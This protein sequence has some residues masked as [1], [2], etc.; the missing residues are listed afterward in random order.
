MDQIRKSVG[1]GGL[2]RQD[3]VVAVQ[4]L[5]NRAI[6][7]IAL[8][9]D[10]RIGPATVA[11]IDYF[12]GHFLGLRPDGRVDPNGPT[13]IKLSTCAA[14]PRRGS[15]RIDLPP[16]G[17]ATRL[18]DADFQQA[19][20]KLGCDVAVIQAVTEVESKGDGFLPSKRPKILFEA[21]I[22]SRLTFHCFDRTHSDVSSKS[23]NKKLYKGDDGEYARLTK[24]MSL[25]RSAALQSASWGMFQIMGFN[26]GACGYSSVD[27]FVRSMFESEAEHL[28]SFVEFV[29][30][31]QLEP[32]LKAKN[33]S[34]FAA[35]YN[36]PDYEENAYHVK[37][38]MAY[39]KF[40][41][42]K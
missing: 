31:S 17:S 21:H 12:Q 23:W 34:A 2:N 40:A 28:L 29:K 8:S 18:R 26:Y 20:T 6:G 19:A 33:W 24:A 10:G 32:H 14:A 15:D 11:A 30:S 16:V 4:R 36:G 1:R 42:A 38:E 13:L 22:F 9:E 27:E 3:D 41:G 35:A 39:K 37:L 5:L 25:D 7:E